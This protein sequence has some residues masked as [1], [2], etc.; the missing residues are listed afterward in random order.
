MLRTRFRLLLISL[1]SI[2]AATARP[3]LGAEP[4]RI[5]GS[6]TVNPVV[7]DAAD[8]FRAETGSTVFVD[9]QGGSS[10]GIAA[11]GEGRAEIGMISRELEPDDRTKFPQVK[12]QATR[13]GT[14]ALA[15]VVS[16]DVWAGGVKVLSRSQ[17]QGIYEG[18]TTN[19][20]ALG[21]PDRRIVFF[22][23]EPGRGTWEAFAK[24]LYGD[25]K[26][27]P[28][29]SFPEVGAN[30]EGR[31]KVSSTRGAL[32]QLSAAWADGKTVFA[33]AIRRDDGKV[34]P[35]TTAAIADGSYPIARPLQVVTN[36]A[37]QGLAK[38]MI[39]LLLSPRGQAL[40]TRHGYLPLAPASAKKRIP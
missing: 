17:M 33:L 1:A 22:N 37:P 15:L 35:P 21:G 14:D 39:D 12:F 16:K 10:G 2:L 20:K 23:K 13:I 34:V 19:W 11:L 29:V 26:K 7:V 6:T 5:N 30:E 8:L 31:N 36:G 40:V 28:V 25:P 38:G 3:A 32:S 24:W 27:A 4:L 18:R 9:T